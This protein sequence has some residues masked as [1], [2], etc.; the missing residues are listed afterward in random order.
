MRRVGRAL[1]HTSHQINRALDA[2]I[3]EA[4]SEELTGMRGMVLG[5]IVRT[6]RTGRAVYQRDLERCFRV[7]RS[8]ITTMLKGIEQAGFITRTPVA[9]DARLKSLAATEKGLACY[10][11]LERCINAFEARLQQNVSEEELSHLEEVL[12]R[13]LE[14]AKAVQSNPH[15]E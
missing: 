1:T 15:I 11:Q 9:E 5:Y 14:N 6:T 12:D 2:C 3:C 8:S 4:V 10:D 13:L 7:Q